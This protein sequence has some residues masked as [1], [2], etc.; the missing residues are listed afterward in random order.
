M[1]TATNVAIGAIIL[2]ALVGMIAY[3]T[4]SSL[5]YQQ[6]DAEKALSNID[7]QYQRRADLIPRMVKV[8]E[9]SMKFQ[10]K[11]TSEYA[12]AREGFDAS[13]TAYKD[14]LKNS[15]D[16]GAGTRI[17]QAW[18]NVQDNWKAVEMTINARS[19]SVPQAN[20]DQLTELNN[21]MAAIENVISGKRQ[22]YNEVV[23]SYNKVVRIPPSSW[24]ASYW[25]FDEMN[26]FEAKKGAENAPDVDMNLNI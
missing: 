14:A 8:A 2:V 11:L 22:A 15:K 18:Q 23:A 10:L 24:F 7:T 26:M 5:V 16:V 25:N 9:T 4:Y 3:G 20:L 21:E 12:K 1:G 13:E 6:I 19:E 17:D